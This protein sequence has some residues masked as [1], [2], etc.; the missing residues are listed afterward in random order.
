MRSEKW[1]EA[2]QY[3]RI[4][5]LMPLPCVDLLIIHEGK[6]LLM[7][8][9]NEPGKGE[10]F[11]PGGRILHGET[12]E[13]AVLRN[14]EDETGLIPIKIDKIDVMEHIWPHTHTVTIFHRIKVSDDNVVMNDEHSEY[15]WVQKI[16]ERTHPFLLYM[17]KE[18]K[19]FQV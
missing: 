17:I 3:E 1:I 9:K 10:W 4:K 16:P 8:R 13:E 11:A 2:S 5:Q 18:A 15:K 6:L 12:I 7:L 14:L 19:I